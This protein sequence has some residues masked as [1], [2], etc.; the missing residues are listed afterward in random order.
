MPRSHD[1]ARPDIVL[2]NGGLFESR[3]IQERVLEVL[4]GW[5]RK[6]DPRWSP[7][8]L[9][10]DRLDLAVARGAAYYG[11]V[12]RGQGERIAAGLARTY[13]IGVESQPPAAVCLVPAGVEPGQDV[14]LTASRSFDLLISEPVEFPLLASSTRLVDKPGDLVL[15]D[16]E[17]MT[18]LPPIRTV[19]RTRKKGDSG[20]VRVN[21]HARLTE[22]GALDLWCS[23]M[24]GR[25]SWRLVFDV[26][27]ATQTD[28]AARDTHR[29]ARGDAG[30]NDLARDPPLIEATFGPESEGEARG[31]GQ[32]A[33]RGHR[34]QSQPMAQFAVAAN[35]GGARRGRAGPAPQPGP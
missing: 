17:Q 22:I 16:R 4:T 10:N 32:A 28:V 2:F 29:R 30:R 35:L 14:D 13:Y 34:R 26:R 8:V 6:D 19:L 33:H 21:L 20:A 24:E 5:F 11:M 18:P 7:L 3:A 1:P 15:I 27:S 25:G 31:A 9:D 12:R 23:E